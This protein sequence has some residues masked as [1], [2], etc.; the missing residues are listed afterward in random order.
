MH[1]TIYDST[2]Y[3]ADFDSMNSRPTLLFFLVKTITE[4]WWYSQ[5]LYSA[6][7]SKNSIEQ[8]TSHIWRSYARQ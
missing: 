2:K 8:R 1:L 7:I 4:L 3:N 6:I 5:E